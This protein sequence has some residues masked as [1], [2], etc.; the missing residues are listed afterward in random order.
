V[1]FSRR[2]GSRA[3]G[4]GRGG[5]SAAAS[6]PAPAPLLISPLASDAFQ[7]IDTVYL[8]ATI[9]SG[10]PAV[11]GVEFFRGGSTKIGDAA[12]VNSI[13]SLAWSGMAAA[14][15]SLTA[16]VTYSS[17]ATATSSAVAITVAA[18]PTV[19]P[20]SSAN[21]L[22][23]FDTSDDA[24]MSLSSGLIGQ[25]NNKQ[26]TSVFGDAVQATAALKP[27]QDY[28]RGVKCAYF[29]ADLQER[30]VSTVTGT[31]ATGWKMFACVRPIGRGTGLA[32]CM[33]GGSGGSIQVGNATTIW[34][35][36][37]VVN[38][39]VA[40]PAAGTF[41]A[42]KPHVLM[43]I[44]G[45]GGDL[46]VDGTS[47]VTP[48]STGTRTIT[49]TLSLGASAT[50]TSALS[51]GLAEP[52]V[53]SS[54]MSAGD[55]TAIETALTTKYHTLEPGRTILT[56]GDSILLG[57]QDTAT[58]AAGVRK[59]AW[60]QVFAKAKVNGKWLESIGSQPASQ[61]L[62]IDDNHF[63]N[64]GKGIAYT[65][66]NIAPLIGS[67]NP[68]NPDIFE[69]MLVTNN[70]REIAPETYVA[71]TGPGTT[72]QAFI[73][74]CVTTLLGAVPTAQMI[75]YNIIDCDPALGTGPTSLNARLRVWN[76]LLAATIIRQSKPLPVRRSFL[77]TCSRLW[78][79]STPPTTTPTVSTRMAPATTA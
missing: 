5:V 66:T 37:A 18:A 53:G 35:K 55:I 43:G 26:G 49:A 48:A 11:T 7:L 33:T 64:S 9:P 42:A 17:G 32:V 8:V 44:G 50:G 36:D 75:I 47:A 54:S 59:R 1:T 69:V 6:S 73:D 31:V 74:M 46:H 65:V 45:T 51:G 21:T 16:K 39:N 40:L 20:A 62:F 10:A 3:N 70:L 58:P 27:V 68:Y 78:A 12:L 57:F 22:A 2:L 4:R 34:P 72:C 56:V 61:A 23:W 76:P 24:N 13:W 41:P 15:Y 30:L 71:G 19:T 77:A 63:C 60:D 79:C 25:V 52:C 14:S 29:G 38:A 28:I 67:G